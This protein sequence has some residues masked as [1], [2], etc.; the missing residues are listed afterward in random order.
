MAKLSMSDVAGAFSKGPDPRDALKL[1]SSVKGY[2]DFKKQLKTLE[3]DGGALRRAMDREIR[4]VIKPVAARAQALVPDRPLSGWRLGN[5]RVGKLNMPDWDQ[6][7][8]RKNIKLKQGGRRSRGNA[9]QA[10]WKITNLSAAGS[11][12]ELAGKKNRGNPRMGPTFI[13]ALTL[14]HGKP[15][16]LIWR[17]WDEA[18]GEKKITADVQNIVK[19]YESKLELGLKAAKD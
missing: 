17:A 13:S 4:A 10:A 11:V 12:L 19:L 15:S 6:S 3:P 14:Y 18:G 5:G 1:E 2:N 7:E 16:R 9:T 8:V